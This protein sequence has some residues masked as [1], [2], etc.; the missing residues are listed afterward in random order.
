MLPCLSGFR[1][2][3]FRDWIL[4]KILCFD[5]E[6]EMFK[7][8]VEPDNCSVRP[9][10]VSVVSRGLGVVAIEPGEMLLLHKYSGPKMDIDGN[11]HMF[12]CQA[13]ILAKVERTRVED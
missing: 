4:V 13:D 9:L 5:S 11:E 6:H 12:I 8:I 10:L 7:K 3:P 2:A 1:I